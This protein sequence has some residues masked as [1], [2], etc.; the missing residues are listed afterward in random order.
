MKEVW[1]RGIVKVEKLLLKLPKTLKEA[2]I[3]NFTS[4]LAMICKNDFQHNNSKRWQQF[5][6]NKMFR[7]SLLWTFSLHSRECLWIDWPMVYFKYYTLNFHIP[8]K[9]YNIQIK[10]FKN[11]IHIVFE[12]SAQLQFQSIST[13]KEA[14]FTKKLK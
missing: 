4:Y 5:T 11:T 14:A 6:K 1:I 10:N 2:F 9:Q 12:G 3:S 7:P 8:W 13:L